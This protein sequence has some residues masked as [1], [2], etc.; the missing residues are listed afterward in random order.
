M[1]FEVDDG[2]RP[3][4]LRLENVGE[5]AML[6]LAISEAYDQANDRSQFETWCNT[7]QVK[8]RKELERYGVKVV[9]L[10]T[11]MGYIFAEPEEDEDEDEEFE[12]DG[13]SPE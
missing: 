8:L 2:F 11:D 5:L 13:D 10:D 1:K 4:N 3:V 6:W 9:K 12:D 7:L